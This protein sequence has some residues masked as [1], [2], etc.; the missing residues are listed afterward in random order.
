MQHLVLLG[1]SGHVV[2]LCCDKSQLASRWVCTG[3][4]H[5]GCTVTRASRCASA[6]PSGKWERDL[7]T[8]V[9]S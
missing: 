2:S 1:C 5:F 7:D 4:P 6:S 8:V 9:S 3:L